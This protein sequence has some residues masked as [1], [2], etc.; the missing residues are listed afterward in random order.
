M[1]AAEGARDL[2]KEHAHL[3]ALLDRH[4]SEHPPEGATHW[5]GHVGPH[6]LKWESHTEFFTYTLFVGMPE[7]QPF[8]SSAVDTFLEGWLDQAP[9]VRMTSVRIRVER[10]AAAED[11]TASAKAWFVCDSLAMARVLDD[12]LV[13]AGDFRIDPEGHVRFALWARPEV[14]ERRVGRV[15]QRLCEIETYKAMAL[16]G[17]ALARDLGP[18]MA[19]LDARLSALVAGMAAT[20]SP[21]DSLHALLALSS[22]LE[23][24]LAR[25]TFRFGATAAYEALVSDRI[26][27][28]R[29]ERFEGRQTMAEFM[30]RRFDP[31]MRTTAS[32]GR[33]L[34]SMSD[35]AIRAG[36]LLRT[37]VDV[38]R[39]AESRALLASMDRR[40]DLALRLQHTVEGLSVLAISYYAVGL[41]LYLLGPLAHAVD[42]AW[43][44]AGLTP[45]VILVVWFGIRR[46]RRHVE[47][48]MTL[49]GRGGSEMDARS[50]R[51]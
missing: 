28:L 1:P 33:R 49:G 21:E 13:V 47:G 26:E 15:V 2:A 45:A 50:S 22:E 40:A 19:D 29:E 42:K 51:F 36:D 27:M 37:R 8:S 17:F 39:G 44:A 43:L 3:R 16:L 24:M 30:K 46:V 25:S 31:A 10:L 48:G 18:A 14:N 6:R 4:G 41:S 9:G 11:V 7:E 38:E 23:A 32:T 35:R 12:E 5:Y 34:Q 20:D